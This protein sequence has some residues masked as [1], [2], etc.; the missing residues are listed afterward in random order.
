[1]STYFYWQVS[2]AVQTTGYVYWDKANLYRSPVE[3]ALD[4]YSL[5]AS[6]PSV[7]GSVW[8][9]NYTDATVGN[10]TDK[11][12]IV[13]YYN[14]AGSI[15]DVNIQVTHFPF[16]PREARIVQITQ[17]M[18]DPR[19]TVGMQDYDFLQA[20]NMSL[21]MFNSYPPPTCFTWDNLPYGYESIIS[22]GAMIAA[23]LQRFL[24]VSMRDFDYSDN[25][26]ALHLN[27]QDKMKGAV[28]EVWRLYEPM[29]KLFKLEEAPQGMGIGSWAIPLGV[30]R[31]SS[32]LMNVLDLYRS[33]SY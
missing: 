6:I 33:Y 25:G 10:G 28:D 31:V 17:H 13:K 22:M 26:L 9:V 15:E 18:M 7:V 23:V 8:T 19:L 2:S 16:S 5:V 11:F 30:G 20:I 27:L 32:A 24:G 12:Y 21:Q 14:T 29:I 4:Q 1:M 3:N